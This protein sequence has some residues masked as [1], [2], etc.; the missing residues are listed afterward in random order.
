MKPFLK[1]SCTL[2]RVDIESNPYC[3]YEMKKLFLNRVRMKEMI[4]F[5]VSMGFF[6]L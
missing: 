5:L 6:L 3:P 2:T 4:E 1:E